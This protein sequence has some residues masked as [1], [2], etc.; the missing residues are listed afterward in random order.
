MADPKR[1]HFLPQFYLRQFADPKETLYQVEKSSNPSAVPTKVLR[2]GS[3]R[4]Y[5]TLDWKERPA[6]RAT[7][8]N[9][10]SKLESSQAETLKV[11]L[12]NPDS[13]DAHLEDLFGFVTFMYHRVPG[14]KRDIEV[15]LSQMVNASGRLLFRAGKLPGPPESIKKLIREK[16]D[17]IFNAEISNWKLIEM[18]FDLAARSPMPGFMRLM[19][20]RLLRVEDPESFLITSDCPVVLYE[21]SQSYQ[22]LA[23]W[24]QASSPATVKLKKRFSVEHLARKA[25]ALPGV[26]RRVERSAAMT[27]FVSRI[28]PTG[29]QEH[30]RVSRLLRRRR[31]S[32]R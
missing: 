27:K 7:V 19:N 8:E 15:G 28:R 17:D 2:S 9:E 26:P 23:D 29:R 30:C 20:C 22:T 6:D 24:P 3:K 18:M 1:H 25:S 4:N 31:D 12:A 13:V 10:L 14:F 11:L 16:G 5:H 32:V 21:R